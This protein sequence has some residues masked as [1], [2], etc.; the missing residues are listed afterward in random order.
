[1]YREPKKELGKVNSAPGF[2]LITVGKV[3][4]NSQMKYCKTKEKFRNISLGPEVQCLRSNF[5]VSPQK[6]IAV[7]QLPSKTQITQGISKLFGLLR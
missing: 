5:S 2:T 1:M 7:L 4:L 6:Y 3:A